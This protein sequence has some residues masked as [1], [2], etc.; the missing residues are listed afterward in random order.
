MKNVVKSSQRLAVAGCQVQPVRH[1]T[2]ALQYRK[3]SNVAILKLP[4]G[5]QLDVFRG[6]KDLVTNC[7]ND[8]MAVGIG[9]A[10]LLGLSM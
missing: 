7:V 9:V 8:V 5:L 2:N 3:G 4:W 10:F 1:L 6:K